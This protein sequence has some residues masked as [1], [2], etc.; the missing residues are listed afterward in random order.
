M[1]STAPDSAQALHWERARLL[2]DW[3]NIWLGRLLAHLVSQHTHP[4]LLCE[5]SCSLKHISCLTKW[6]NVFSCPT[7]S[8]RCLPCCMFVCVSDTSTVLKL[9]LVAAMRGDGTASQPNGHG[10]GALTC[11]SKLPAAKVR[12]SYCCF[13]VA[14][15]TCLLGP[16][17]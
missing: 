4:V 1:P 13:A 2:S 17:C 14:T 8:G 6:R 5:L 10:P 16:N 12:T 9:M 3:H 11:L 15:A 7:S